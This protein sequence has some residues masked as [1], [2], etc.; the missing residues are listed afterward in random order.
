MYNECTSKGYFNKRSSG[1]TRKSSKKAR[2]E[3]EHLRQRP[4]RRPT[5][6]TQ[7]HL[8]QT[9]IRRRT[10]PRNKTPLINQPPRPRQATRRDTP[11]PPSPNG[12]MY[13]RAIAPHLPLDRPPTSPWMI[14]TTTSL[15]PISIVRRR[16]RRWP[17]APASASTSPKTW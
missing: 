8:P 1:N 11:Q 15:R 5:K 4:H 6:G 10:H 7:P 2:Q 14:G 17:L 16:P 9:Q 12:P 3:T 13:R